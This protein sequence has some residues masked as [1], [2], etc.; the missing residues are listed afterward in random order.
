[1]RT[2]GLKGDLL[3]ILIARLSPGLVL[4]AGDFVVV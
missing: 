4:T 3:P 1:M 2:D